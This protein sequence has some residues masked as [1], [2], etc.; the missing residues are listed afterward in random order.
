MLSEL[1]PFENPSTDCVVNMSTFNNWNNSIQFLIYLRA[2]LNSLW[3]IT[4]SARMLRQRINTTY[5]KLTEE[6]TFNKT[7]L[8]KFKRGYLKMST[9]LQT[10]FAAET[11]NNNNKNSVVLVR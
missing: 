6:R 1:L 2:E 4:E 7:R 11:H 3:P 10:V 5:R 8:F 9:D